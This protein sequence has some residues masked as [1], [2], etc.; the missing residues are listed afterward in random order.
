MDY[1]I[2]KLTRRIKQL[3]EKLGEE[4]P[5]E[6]QR[7][8]MHSIIAGITNEGRRAAELES[9]FENQD[10]ENGIK[11]TAARIQIALSENET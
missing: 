5:Q 11:R 3:E 8:S 1:E 2:E 6:E 10:S 9:A 7:E 4:H